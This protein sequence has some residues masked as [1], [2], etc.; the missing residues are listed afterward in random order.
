M[1]DAA[2]T[3]ATPAPSRPHASNEPLPRRHYGALLFVVISLGV[4]M[5][6][7]QLGIFERGSLQWWLL[8][9]TAVLLPL[10]DAG[11][12]V[13]RLFGRAWPLLVFLIVSAAWH[14]F[15][16]DLHAILQLGLLVWVTAWLSSGR[17]TLRIDDLV[18][19]YLLFIAI[20]VA[21]TLTT[22]FNPYGLIPGRSHVDYGV[23][24]VSFFPNIAYSGIF[25]LAMVMLLTHDWETTKRHR[26]TLAV[27]AYFLLSSFVRSAIICLLLYLVLRLWF[28]RRSAVTPRRIFWTVL[29]A[30]IAANALLTIAPAIVVQVQSLPLVSHLLLQSKSGLSEDEIYKQMYRTWLWAQHF[31]IFWESPGLMGWGA[32]DFSAKVAGLDIPLKSAGN[33]SLPTRLLAAYGIPGIIFTLYCVHSLAIAGRR[34]DVWGSTAFA[35]VMCLMLHWGSA[36]HPSDAIY[37][38]YMLMLLQGSQGFVWTGVNGVERH[39]LER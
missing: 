8:I 23:L 27:A 6:L 33:E 32:F 19:I 5:S 25:S 24:R 28:E 17:V 31:R 4:T 3:E 1:S 14:A 21:L 16:L 26:F 38:T 34:G 9:A 12:T 11:R 37:V 15:R 30:T 36:F 22:D 10:P 39:S 13:L 35:I 2:T 18:K 29:V 7:H 20:G